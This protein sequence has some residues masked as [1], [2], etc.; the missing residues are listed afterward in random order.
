MND[1]RKTKKQLV[2]DLQRER[3][4]SNALQEVS[5]R[6]AGAHD[7][8]EVLDLIVNEAARLLGASAAFI[9][10][11]EGGVLVPSA[12]TESATGYLA[13]SADIQPTLAVEAG[14]S[15]VGHVMASKKPLVVEN[16][17]DDE[18]ITPGGRLAQEK[19]GFH[20][21]AGVPLVA[22]ERSIGVLI[23]MDISLR[24]FNEDEVSLLTAF[25]DQAS[26]ALEKAR[27]LNEAERERERSDALYQISNRLAGAHDTDEVLDL[28]VNEA[29][30]LVGASAAWIRLLDGD[31][32]I[33]S[34]ATESATAYIAEHAKIRPTLAVGE[35]ASTVG[36]VMSTKK[37]LV[38]EDYPDLV[39]PEVRRI[40][41]EHG[42]YG[43]A[44][45]PLVANDRSIG[46]LTVTDNRVRLFTEDEVSLLT[47]FADQ[48]ALALDKARLLNEAERE[49]G[50][51]AALN[52]VVSDLATTLN[53]EAVSQKITDSARSL[54][55]AR[56]AII[57]QLD[58]STEILSL[59][60]LSGESN[61]RF[62]ED[63]TLDDPGAVRSL[64][65]RER[66]TLVTQDFLVDNR[67]THTQEQQA[68]LEQTELRAFVA[69]PFIVQDRVTGVLTVGDLAGRKFTDDEIQLTEAFADQASV[70]LE[71]ARLLNEA[72]REKERSD[73]LYRVSNQLA[74]THNTHEVLDLIVNE[75]ARLLGAPAAFIRLLEGDVLVAGAATESAAAFLE[76]T[77]ADQA[78]LAV[79][80]GASAMGHVMATKKPLV[81]EDVAKAELVSPA[82]RLIAEKHDFHAAAV[83]PLLA[84]DRSIGV[85][86]V[87]DN[88]VH[89]FT[90]DEVS[91]LAAFADQASLALEKARLLN[92]AEAR[93]RQATQLY[94]VTTQLASNHDLH[95]LLDLITQQAVDL[96]GGQGGMIFRYNDARGG[97]VVATMHNLN[98][99][100]RDM[101]VRP[102]EG[103]AG[104]AY[105]ERRAVW[106]DDLFADSAVVY[107]DD[108]SQMI[109]QQQASE[110]GV[111]GVVAAPIMIRDEVYG[112]LDVV[113]DKHREFTDEEVNLVQTLA[114]SAAVAIN[115]AR[116]IEETEQARDEATQLYKITE[117]LASSPD[118]DSVL[119][120][121]VEKAAE[122]LS[123]EASSLF[124]FDVE[125][126]GLVLTREHNFLTDEDTGENYFFLPGVGTVGRAFRD[127]KP[128]W[129]NDLHENAETEYPDPSVR[130]T[131]LNSKNR[132]ALSAPIIIRDQVYGCLTANY[133]SV[134]EFGEAEAQLLQTLAD[135]AAVAIGNARFIE[136]T[137]QARD[138]AEDREREAIQLQ[139]VTTQL[140]SNTEMDSVLELITRSASALLGSQATA[141][142]RYDG[143][144]DGLSVIG[145][146]NVPSDW[147]GSIFVRPGD[148]TTGQAFQKRRPVWS[149]NVQT[150][151]E[152]VFSEEGMETMSRAARI[153]GALAVPI[154]IRNE[155]Y[156]VLNSFFYEPHDFSDGEVQLLQTL[157]DS[158]AVAIGNARFIEETQQARDVAEEANRTKSQFLANMSHELR[159][160]L[161]A[162]IGYSEMLQ[163]E[164][165]DQGYEDFNE[166]LERI[167][168]A[169][170][171]LLGLINDVL[172]ISKIEAGGMDIYLETFPIA[173]MIQDVMTT[174]QPLVDNNSNTLE[175]DCPDSVGSIHADMTKVRQSLFN[176]LSNSSKFTE[177]GTIS[178][179]V[180]RETKD[181]RE[182]VNFV[183]GDTGI[184]MTEEQMGHLFEAFAQA[185]ASTSRRFGGTGLG[186]AITKHFCEMMGG[187]ILV[188][189]E[190]G[191]GST[192]TM[193]LPAVVADPAA[194]DSEQPAPSPTSADEVSPA[195]NTVLV[196]DDDASV[197]DL[198]QRSLAGQGFTLVRAMGGEEGLRLAKELSPVVITLDVMMPGMDGWAVL[199]ALKADPDLADIPVIMVT[200]IDQKNL[201]YALGA[202]EYLTK[203]IDRARLLSVLNKY[204]QEITHGPVLV[205]DD[206]PS[207]RE[208]V[209][210]MLEKEGWDVAEAENGRV[211]LD[212]L[213]DTA[214]SLIL[215]DLMMPE[216]DG[217]EFI[218]ELRRIDR[219]KRVP[220]VVVTAKDITNEDRQRLNGYVEKVVQKGS[221]S[222]E[223]LMTELRGLVNAFAGTERT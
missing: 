178:L 107:S 38:T 175:I 211:A 14:T 170:K 60:S 217:F 74:G 36:H 218:E 165:Q 190:S 207:V 62:T 132:A 51:L 15:L 169:G 88:R 150:D 87:L 73:A 40:L 185:E 37:P 23:V 205:V 54:I 52:D 89:G 133:Y 162:I 135:S 12:S 222:T 137:Q 106:T 61:P 177:Q 216:M 213:D 154:I 55:G 53:F 214:P 100:M 27:L 103:N 114:D 47:A 161:N 141:I 129:K 44:S 91:L 5:N 134:H 46:V 11:L 221:Y 174:I 101:F 22:N 76:E 26:L 19:Y 116:F 57:F 158:A 171:H 77:A 6:L 13:A 145:G 10:L 180:S 21:W 84:N 117:Q 86:A 156:G 90:E 187:E 120:L 164:A 163:E 202:A 67:L 42:F 200:I 98:P 30:R 78:G 192:F 126:G 66:Q 69:V 32:M 83:V 31:V 9:R 68:S 111:V 149:S 124:S 191:K 85:L 219:W 168:G 119:D 152:W 2:E 112:I 143:A 72:E 173:P 182:W 24:R 131:V 113:F 160:P 157:A 215:L 102:G 3:E 159:T 97:L 176:L 198:M 197:H 181:G 79:G 125:K 25:A 1:Q 155:I 8:D 94:E 95:S 35:D 110:W 93:E 71:N 166:D 146:Y 194:A 122:L 138:M 18:R 81:V 153:G 50:R 184:G 16:A 82:Q 183:V 115:N 65:A 128:V 203:P 144:A 147:A 48:A 223:S 210:R 127:R 212:L 188:E 195:A 34:A 199:S 104:R 206:D 17:S 220:V 167:H 140:A 49:R 58:R 189:S 99:E 109:V 59:I 28:I 204:K 56:I 208:M 209:R 186:L 64:A 43:S 96:T 33:P 148:G 136:E 70:A 92:E 142:W 108:E 7:T 118:M 196:I 20:G 80:E 179:T 193:K 121:I 151:S 63:F 201:G 123:S 29:A 41:H 4:R 139:E 130:E 75:A 39:P 172:D 45:V 105:V